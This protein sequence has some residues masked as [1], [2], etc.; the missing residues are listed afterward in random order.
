MRN[1]SKFNFKTTL[2]LK[3]YPIFDE[4]TKLCKAPKDAYNWGGWLIL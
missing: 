3:S 2:L 1:K 4:A